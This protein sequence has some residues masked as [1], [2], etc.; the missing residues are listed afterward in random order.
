MAAKKKAKKSSRRSA[1]RVPR[2]TLVKDLK[3]EFGDVVVDFSKSKL[4]IEF[5]PSGIPK[6]DEALGGGLPK[7]RM[8]EIFGPE[9]SGKTSLALKFAALVQ[10]AGGQVGFVDAEHALSTEWAMKIGFDPREAILIQP[11]SGEQALQVTR[12]MVKKNVDLVIVDSAASLVPQKELDGEVGDS[13]I[14]LQARL[15]SQFCRMITGDLGKSDSTVVVINQIRDKVGVMFG[16]PETTSGGRALK[17]YSSVRVDVR[18]KQA[19]KRTGKGV[20]GFE[21]KVRVVKNKVAPP[22]KEAFCIIDFEK[23]VRAKRGEG[24]VSKKTTKKTATRTT[25]KRKKKRSK[26]RRTE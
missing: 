23:G 13:N 20:I 22:F 7:G 19:M 10:S 25:R 21:T 15:L 1:R 6:I 4:N 2:Q 16:N 14:A 17:F 26:K 5:H 8:V 18:K 11:D 9:S 3:D 12:R 24:V